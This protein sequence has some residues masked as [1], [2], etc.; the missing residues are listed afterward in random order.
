MNL[1][2]Y[3]FLSQMSKRNFEHARRLAWAFT[4]ARPPLE[5]G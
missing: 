2:I 1:G 5:L 3:T 4:L